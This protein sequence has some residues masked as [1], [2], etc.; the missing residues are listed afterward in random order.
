MV[1][2]LLSRIVSSVSAAAGTAAEGKLATV[3]MAT[4]LREVMITAAWAGFGL[5]VR[6]EIGETLCRSVR[7][8]GAIT[9]FTPLMEAFSKGRDFWAWVGLTPRPCRNPTSSD[10]PGRR[11]NCG[12]VPRSWR[13]HGPLTVNSTR[14][15]VTP[16]RGP[17]VTVERTRP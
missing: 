13:V 9:T 8:W 11:A 5:V 2:V 15:R 14:I 12:C 7:S 17:L 1:N 10:P 4:Y 6:D 3:A 16:S